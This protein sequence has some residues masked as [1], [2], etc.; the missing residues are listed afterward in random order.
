MSTLNDIF[1]KIEDKTEL[2]S[3]EVSLATYQSYVKLD[4]AA[5]KSKDKSLAVVKKAKDSLI[6]ASNNIN[7][8]IIAFTNVIS[9]IDALEKQAK[10]LGLPIPNDARVARDS[11]K[12][13]LSQFNEL[14]T[15]VNSVK[16]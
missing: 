2:A 12:R 10:D 8:T 7:A 6:D 13:E 15:K 11:A 5:L 1:K 9:E 16:L 14:K 3:Q 4:D